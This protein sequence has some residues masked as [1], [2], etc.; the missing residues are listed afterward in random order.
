MQPIQNI[1]FLIHKPVFFQFWFD[2]YINKEALLYNT[3]CIWKESNHYKS[4][5]RSFVGNHSFLYNTDYS[6]LILHTIKSYSSP[7]DR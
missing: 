2:N 6:V 1:A 7:M 3:S 4:T 5:G